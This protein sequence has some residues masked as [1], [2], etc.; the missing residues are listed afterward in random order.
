MIS[1]SFFFSRVLTRLFEDVRYGEWDP[2]AEQI[3]AARS[4]SESAIDQARREKG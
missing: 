1:P 4:L 2:T 3:D